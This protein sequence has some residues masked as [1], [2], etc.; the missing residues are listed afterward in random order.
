MLIWLVTKQS[1]LTLHIFKLLFR[2]TKK[3]TICIT[4][5]VNCQL[6]FFWSFFI[7]M[8]YKGFAGGSDGKECTQRRRPRFYP[9][10]R[11]I[12]WRREWLPTPVCLPGELQEPSLAGYSHGVA[13]FDRTE[14]LIHK[15][16]L[17]SNNRFPLICSIFV[18]FV[19]F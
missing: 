3:F 12:P 10:V 9:W 6:F 8:T 18:P 2:L 1:Y 5:L 19:N 7:L 4:S 13:G 17:Y 14:P 15:G 16:S 11:K